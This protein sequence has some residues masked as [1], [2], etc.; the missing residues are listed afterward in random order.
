[1]STLWQDIPLRRA[2]ALEESRDQRDRGPCACARH[3]RQ[4][5]DLQRRPSPGSRRMEMFVPVGQLSDQT[6]WQ[7][8]GNHPGLYGVGRL[9][10]GVT[11]EQADADMNTIAANLE[12]QYADSNTGSRVRM[13]R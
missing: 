2:N 5:R 13:R 8:R 4:Q 1:M 11:F 9:K 6:S 12:K 7:S 3:R 10:P